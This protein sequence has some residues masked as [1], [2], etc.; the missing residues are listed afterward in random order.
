MRIMQL[1]F[2]FN[3]ILVIWGGCVHA[4]ASLYSILTPSSY[5]DFVHYHFP[6]N[7]CRK[8]THWVL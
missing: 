7:K 1:V 8:V 6:K 5:F 4:Y 3:N 2:H